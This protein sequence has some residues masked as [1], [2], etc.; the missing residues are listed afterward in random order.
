MPDR[1]FTLAEAQALLDE[2]VRP[3]AERM[4]ELCA[5]VEPLQREWRTIVIAIGSNGGGLDHER[6]SALRESLEQAQAEVG[7]LVDEVLALGVQVKDPGPGAARLPGGDRRTTGAAVLAGGRAADRVLA[8]A[9][10]WVR[11]QA[12]AAV[13]AG[14]HLN[15]ALAAERDAY[16]EQLAGRPSAARY[17]AARD[18]YLASHA[19]T[20]PR[21]WGRL[22]GALKMAILADDGVAE[23][24]AQALADAAGV[25]GPAAGYARAL[26]AVATGAAPETSEMLAAGD[27]FARTGRALQALAD[28]DAAGY[29]A[30]LGEIMADF[31]ARDQH[32]SGVAVADTAMVLE[33]L[34]EPRGMAVH[35]VSALLPQAV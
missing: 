3:L 1:T 14:A 20:G 19:E 32:L 5:A 33:R 28:G 23:V 11:G 27:A 34:A 8:H 2:V 25:E 15:A 13:S 12:A 21:S 16:A 18:A 30:A 22:I 35:P 26:A 7:E 9:G 31:E 4:V 17:R 24:A 6:A 29:R 10:G